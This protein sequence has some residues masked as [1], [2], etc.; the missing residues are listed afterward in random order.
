MPAAI[1][2]IKCQPGI[3][4]WLGP[5]TTAVPSLANTVTSQLRS[6]E[7]DSQCTRPGRGPLRSTEQLLRKKF[8]TLS[9]A[10]EEGSTGSCN[11]RQHFSRQTVALNAALKRPVDETRDAG[12]CRVADEVRRLAGPY[13]HK[14]LIRLPDHQWLARGMQ[15]AETRPGTALHQ[16]ISMA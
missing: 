9:K 6:C 2:E 1:E 16:A 12:L 10:D 3:G 5:A 14:Q 4:A 15:A 7:D 13:D 11:S 8:Q